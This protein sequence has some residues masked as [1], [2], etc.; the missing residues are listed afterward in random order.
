MMTRAGGSELSETYPEFA[1]QIS[2]EIAAL[3]QPA[4]A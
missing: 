3:D 2:A 1:R 4:M